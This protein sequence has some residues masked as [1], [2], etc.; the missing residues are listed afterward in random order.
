MLNNESWLVHSNLFTKHWVIETKDWARTL[1]WFTD[2]VEAS[3]IDTGWNITGSHELTVFDYINIIDELN[4]DK[5]LYCYKAG[6]WEHI[7]GPVLFVVKKSSDEVFI[8][9][10]AGEK[11]LLQ[12]LKAKSSNPWDWEGINMI[13]V[14]PLAAI[15]AFT[16]KDKIDEKKFPVFFL[17]NGETNA[18]ENWKHLSTHCA[19]AI[20]VDGIMGRRK[21]FHKCVDL[22][23][24]STHFFVVTGKNYVT[25]FSVFDFQITEN[26]PK[27][28]IMFQSKNMSNRLEYGHMGI[29]LYNK[30]IVLNTPENF[31][32]DFTECGGV[33]QVPRTVSEA[34][35]ATSPFEAWRTAFR[36]TVKLTLSDSPISKTWLQRWMTFAEGENAEWVIQGA[37]QGYEFAIDNKHK[38]EVL[39]QSVS[40]EWLEEYFKLVGHLQ[41]L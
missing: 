29:G 19:R 35:F 34:V 26:T 22:A 6:K 25:D 28:H 5:K 39:L 20:R 15:Y 41:S 8:A 18:D 38:P 40:W 11:K 4:A 37:K 1:G 30:D 2:F 17:S 9:G 24:D 36:E 27:S 12:K 33:H 7:N 21:A 3:K 23:G 14:N 16:R 13:E 31:G 32:L 10:W